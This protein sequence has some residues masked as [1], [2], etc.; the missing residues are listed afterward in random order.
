MSLFRCLP[1]I[2]KKLIYSKWDF[3]LSMNNLVPA[4]L[5]SNKEGWIDFIWYTTFTV[6]HTVC[7]NKNVNCRYLKRIVLLL[8]TILKWK[9]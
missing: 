7:T 6:F 9:T 8:T 1:N 4:I 3:K 5:R 2:D